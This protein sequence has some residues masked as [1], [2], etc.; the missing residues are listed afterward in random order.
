LWVY[1]SLDKDDRKTFVRPLQSLRSGFYAAVAN[2]TYCTSAIFMADIFYTFLY[3]QQA[4]QRPFS[5]P[6]ETHSFCKTQ[7]DTYFS[8]K[9]NEQKDLCGKTKIYVVFK[10]IRNNRSQ[11][12][13]ISFALLNIL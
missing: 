10:R 12:K 5:T 6:I 9:K 2:I 4:R 8:T 11:W 7:K 13:I 1:S 3:P